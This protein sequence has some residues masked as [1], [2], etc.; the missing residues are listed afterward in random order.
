MSRK[1]N[2][3]HHQRSSLINKPE[4]KKFDID[5]S[6]LLSFSFAHLDTSQGNTPDGL[7]KNNSDLIKTFFERLRDYSRLTFNEAKSKVF[8][9]YGSFPPPDKTDF[10]RP[11]HVPI[12][13]C[14]VSF[15][16]QGEPRIIC[17]IIRSVLFI[18]FIDCDHK[19]WKSKKRNT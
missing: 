11:T 13:A 7:A 2:R 4:L 17:H 5:T 10:N 19:F 1:T 14:W 9:V 16:L 18:V 6:K 12:D 8:R 3:A 15:H